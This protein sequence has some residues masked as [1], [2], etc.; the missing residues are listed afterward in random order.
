MN[1]KHCNSDNG[2]KEMIAEWICDKCGSINKQPTPIEM[3]RHNFG[4]TIN[5]VA[6]TAQQHRDVALVEQ[7]ILALEVT[8]HDLMHMRAMFI[9]KAQQKAI[10]P[11]NTMPNG[12][13]PKHRR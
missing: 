7:V 8:K 1:C 2:N 11:A 6:M 9:A 10:Q 3:F 5:D 12:G 13:L 4:L